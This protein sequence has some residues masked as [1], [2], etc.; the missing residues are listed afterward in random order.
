[1]GFR[2]PLAPQIGLI[3]KKTMTILVIDKISQYYNQIIDVKL[4]PWKEWKQNHKSNITALSKTAQE[5][6]VW[7]IE[8]V[9]DYWF[10]DY[11]MLENITFIEIKDRKL[12]VFL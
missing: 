11:E 10:W 7:G 2:L 12:L 9:N 1:M 8:D 3:M 6:L 4:E 5:E